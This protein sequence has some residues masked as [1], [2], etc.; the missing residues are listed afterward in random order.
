MSESKILLAKI[1]ALKNILDSELGDF[2]NLRKLIISDYFSKII[3][4]SCHQ[5]QTHGNS[6]CLS[7]VR[8]IY[9][10]DKSC[11]LIDEWILV[12]MGIFIY[13]EENNY[14]FRKRCLPLITSKLGDAISNKEL[15]LKLSKE[16]KTL[17]RKNK[18]PATYVDAMSPWIRLPGSYANKS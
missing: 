16:A 14:K 6:S 5:I 15:S 18:K 7:L 4:E 12:N 2:I 13:K 8:Q 11:T 10:K 9:S 17:A 3:Q 1:K